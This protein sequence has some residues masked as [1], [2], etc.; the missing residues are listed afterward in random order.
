VVMREGWNRLKSRF[1]ALNRV[2]TEGNTQNLHDVT[3]IKQHFSLAKGIWKALMYP[4]YHFVTLVI[5]QSP[6]STMRISILLH[7]TARNLV[8]PRQ[9]RIS[10]QSLRMIM[11]DIKQ[12]AIAKTIFFQHPPP[13]IHRLLIRESALHRTPHQ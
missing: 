9:P 6:I 3:C 10:K 8:G 4:K 5:R 7:Q 13:R 12:P 2:G 1:R 11:Y